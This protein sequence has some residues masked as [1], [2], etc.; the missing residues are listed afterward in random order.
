MLWS[1]LVVGPFFNNSTA[2]TTNSNGWQSLADK[3]TEPVVAK[4]LVANIWL[5]NDLSSALSMRNQL[6]PGHPIVTKDGLWIGRNWVRVVRQ[7]D[8]DNSIITREQN[9]NELTQQLAEVEQQLEHIDS[10]L[11]T[12]KQDISDKNTAINN[13]KSKLQQQLTKV[14]ENKGQ[15][16][17]SESQLEQLTARAEKIKE[18]IEDLERNQERDSDE[19]VRLATQLVETEELN[20]NVESRKSELEQVREI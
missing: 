2:S 15:Y 6:E 3:V 14:S 5:A 9:I 20:I 19:L 17:A 12:A 13:I 18:Q 7:S 8:N 16:A 10:S 11:K 1:N 4:N